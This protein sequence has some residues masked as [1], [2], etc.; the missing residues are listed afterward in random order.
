MKLPMRPARMPSGT[1]GTRKSATPQKPL[2][3][4][5]PSSQATTDM[6]TMPPW[7]DMPPCQTLKKESGSATSPGRS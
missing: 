5:F 3:D 4:F 2:P 1:S 6:P 7:K